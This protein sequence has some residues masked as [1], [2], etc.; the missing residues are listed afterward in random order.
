MNSLSAEA[1]VGLPDEMLDEHGG[2]ESVVSQRDKVVFR[3]VYAKKNFHIIQGEVLSGKVGSH[4]RAVSADE[5]LDISDK[6]PSR[7][8]HFILALPAK[9]DK[10]ILAVEDISRSCPV[11]PL[12]RWIKWAS[13]QEQEEAKKTEEGASWWRV[14]VKPI[15][16]EE[17]LREMIRQGRV[18]KIEVVKKS[19]TSARMRDTDK[20]RISGP[21][22][23]SAR[24]RLMGLI[25]S[26]LKKENSEEPRNVDPAENAKSM[27]SILGPELESLDL[28]DGWVI[29]K[30]QGGHSKRIN[31]TRISEVF[32]Y[33][34]QTEHRIDGA[35]FYTEVRRVAKRLQAAERMTISWPED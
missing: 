27:A 25:R 14:S 24:E 9:G 33:S 13:K 16:D 7:N 8:Y 10:G 1:K 6:A 21:L 28:D 15:S 30:D 32:I 2:S 19:I 34:Q 20:F 11:T 22:P 35:G 31:P 23:E 26:W 5:E 4:D 18:E 12:V 3:V 29:L 17:H